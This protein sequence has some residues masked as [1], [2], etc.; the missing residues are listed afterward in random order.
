MGRFEVGERT[1]S[2][3]DYKSGKLTG[4][5]EEYIPDPDFLEFPFSNS[6]HIL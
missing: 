6:D 1:S 5:M 3:R 2:V 4:I